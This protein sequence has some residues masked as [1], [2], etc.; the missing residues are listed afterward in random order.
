M[1]LSFVDCR[2]SRSTPDFRLFL[3]DDIIA[4]LKRPGEPTAVM[5]PSEDVTALDD[6]AI[7]QKIVEG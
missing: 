2:G 7:V 6:D 4:K 3:A 5:K 1:D